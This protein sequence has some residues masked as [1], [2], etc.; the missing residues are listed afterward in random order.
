MHLFIVLFR[1]TLKIKNLPFVIE[2]GLAATTN[3]IYFRGWKIG[4][5]GVTVNK[6]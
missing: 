2:L 6:E 5:I 4:Q 3:K 1:E